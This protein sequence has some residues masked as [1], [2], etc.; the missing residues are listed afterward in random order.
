MRFLTNQ[1]ETSEFRRRYRWMLSICSI[2]FGILAF[3]LFYLQIVRGG[4]YE[5]ESENNFVRTVELPSTR[6]I[7]RDR[8]GR[9]IAE[10]RPSYNVY[11][12]PQFFDEKRGLPRLA[13]YLGLGPEEARA[14]GERIHNVT[15][16]K[17]FQ[18]VLAREDINRD[19]LA[20]LETHK[21]ELSGVQV[22]AVPIRSY[23]FGSVAA[24]ALGYMN[25]VSAEELEELRGRGYRPGDRIG[26]TGIERAWESYLR[27]HRGWQKFVV[28]ARGVKK[29]SHVLDRITGEQRQEPVPGQD[30]RLTIDMEL[31]RAIDRA[32]RGQPAGAAMVVDVHTGQV[33]AAYSKPSF[34]LN[35]MTSGVTVAQ[36]RELTDD[37][38]RPLIDKTLYEN[39]FPGSTFKVVSALAGLE[40]GIV[41]PRDQIV[42][43]G[44]HEFGRRTFRCSHAHGMVDL[45]SAIVQSCNV[46]FYKLAEQVGMDR[47]ARYAFDLGFGRRTGIGLNAENPG[48]IPTRAWYARHYPNA[49]RLG[50]TL[51][52][53]IGQGNTKVNLLQLAL[54]YAAIANGGSL[55]VPQIVENVSEPGGRIV[56]ELGPRLRRRLQVSPEH[57]ALMRHALVGVVQNPGGTA[58]ENRL[59]DV[60]VAGKTG[61]AQ[62]AHR[63][64]RPGE[65][66]RQAWY[67]SRDHAWFAGYAPAEDP[68]I[69]IVVLV[70]HGGNGGRNAAPLAMRI[71]G[72]YF[73]EIS[74]EVPAAALARA[75]E[76]PEVRPSGRVWR[77][78]AR[79]ASPASIHR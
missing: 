67:Q 52:A 76:E 4:H 69:A 23:P 25:E 13:D 14:L 58:Y 74:P 24:H 15:G 40:D 62:V 28:D 53:A 57:L 21:Q 45:E 1:G 11:V 70:E 8:A 78:G 17:R 16:L 68:R 27:G 51:N 9:V 54:A 59:E 34:D 31:Q 42:C 73:H 43:N 7:V 39:Y 46:F 6:G 36:A 72:D 2:A 71:I 32:F 3:R 47:I 19:Q 50:F 66:R 44:W 63:A 37:P 48:F 79:Q 12:T 64:P 5:V 60:T 20:T 75:A 77:E 61:T 10:N 30:L 18:Q 29:A 55:Y 56:Q 65:D 33:L 38:Y 41:T 49:F 22:V 35:L 26:R